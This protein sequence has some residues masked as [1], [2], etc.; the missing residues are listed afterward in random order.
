MEHESWSEYKARCRSFEREF[1]D[2][3]YCVSRLR[4]IRM[5]DYLS[6]LAERE[7]AEKE[8]IKD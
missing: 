6:L 2:C 3:R 8:K 1:C 5:A 4:E 7:R